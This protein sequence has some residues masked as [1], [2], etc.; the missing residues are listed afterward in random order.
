MSHQALD[1][2]TELVEPAARI[3]HLQRQEAGRFDFFINGAVDEATNGRSHV[4]TELPRH[5][6]KRSCQEVEQGKLPCRLCCLRNNGS[7]G[8][9]VV[10]GATWSGAYAES[11]LHKLLELLDEQWLF[12]D[13]SIA[14]H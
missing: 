2:V 8:V 9:S 14:Q 1:V 3:E 5:Y 12:I 13:G 4:A 10:C 6:L 11:S 7:W